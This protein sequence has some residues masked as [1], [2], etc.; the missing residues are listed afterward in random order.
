MTI[1]RGMTG[2]NLVIHRELLSSK[3]TTWGFTLLILHVLAAY[4]EA[5]SHSLS[6]SLSVYVREK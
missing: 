3:E 2:S 5:S 4:G 6:A 1:N